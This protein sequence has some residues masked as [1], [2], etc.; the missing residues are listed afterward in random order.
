MDQ[1]RYFFV[2]ED[3]SGYIGV[4]NASGGYFWISTSIE[5]C[6]FWDSIEDAEKYRSI[7]KNSTSYTPKGETWKLMKLNFA[8]KIITKVDPIAEFYEKR[9]KGGECG[10]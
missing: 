9:N 1:W 6:R 2:T 7:W 5:N 4:D 8:H 3:E 10:D